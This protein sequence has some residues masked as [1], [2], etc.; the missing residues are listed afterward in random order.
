MTNY[1]KMHNKPQETEEAV[2]ET[3]PVESKTTS[4][5]TKTKNGI[6]TVYLNVR[7]TMSTDSDIV[8]V[9][10]VKTKIRILGVEGDW[11][12]VSHNEKFGYVL[13]KFIETEN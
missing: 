1:N 10:P 2:E 11:Y 6:T 8:E 3:Q 9:L 7:S 12:Q 4:E 5:M 13:S